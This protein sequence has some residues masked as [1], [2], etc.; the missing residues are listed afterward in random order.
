MVFNNTTIYYEIK[1][2][3]IRIFVQLNWYVTRRN[4]IKWVAVGGYFT[5]KPNNL[6][7]ILVLCFTT[8]QSLV[9]TIIFCFIQKQNNTISCFTKK[10]NTTISCFVHI[11]SEARSCFIYNQNTIIYCFIQKKYYYNFL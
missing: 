11:Y 10:Q 9:R 8:Y 1:N 7:T 2:Q 6:S 4:S 3:Y 5:R